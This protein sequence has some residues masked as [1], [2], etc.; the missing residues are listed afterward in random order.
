LSK[1]FMNLLV[2]VLQVIV[3]ALFYL[4]STWKLIE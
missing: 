2:Q 3:I 1:F 4:Q